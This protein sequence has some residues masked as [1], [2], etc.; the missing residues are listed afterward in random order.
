MKVGEL[1]LLP[2]IRQAPKDTLIIADGFS[3]REQIRQA[4]D[5]EALHPAQVLQLA[6]RQRRTEVAAKYPESIYLQERQREHDSAQRNAVLI[7]GAAALVLLA[8]ARSREARVL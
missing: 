8:L 2:A 7:F 5:R 6:L 4:T 1:T 3:C